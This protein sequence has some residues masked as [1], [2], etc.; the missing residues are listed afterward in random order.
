M[1][2][3]QIAEFSAAVGGFSVAASLVY[4]GLQTRQ[5][6]KT[7]RAL[8]HQG[9]A[10]NTMMLTTPLLDP[11]LAANILKKYG[12]EATDEAVADWQLDLVFWREQTM[13]QDSF[14]QYRAGMLDAETFEMTR[15]H[16]AST[17]GHSACRALWEKRKAAG[18]FAAFV[19]SIIA[20][21][22]SV[23]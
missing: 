12:I 16:I 6:V 15:M 1:T 21:L 10:A 3:T 4:L 20:S 22:P 5:R 2:L 11:S 8:I 13:W 7:S 18:D 17:L 19:E 9:R 14:Q 23:S